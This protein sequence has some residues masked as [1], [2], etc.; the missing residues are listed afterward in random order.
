ME[1]LVEP[2]RGWMKEFMPT[3]LHEAIMRCLEMKDTINMNLL[4]K[5]FIPQGGKETRL[6]HNSWT[7]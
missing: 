4:M 6:P 5:S 1:G 2:L 7:E 3:T